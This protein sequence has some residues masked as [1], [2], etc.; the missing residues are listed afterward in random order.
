MSVSFTAQDILDENNY[1]EPSTTIGEQLMDTAIDWVNLMTNNS[2]A[3]MSGTVG[4]KVCVCTS[5][6]RGVVKLLC[7]LM[8]RAYN[9]KSPNISLG[10][11]SVNLVLQDPQ[12]ALF[13]P[14]VD[15]GVVRLRGRGILRTFG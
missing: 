1:T 11:L 15:E 3:N 13:K 6:Q 14:L 12:Y 4:A 2:I 8:F 9:D 10:Q 7:G 5:K